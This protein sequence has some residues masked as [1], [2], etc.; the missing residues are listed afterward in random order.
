[1]LVCNNSNTR[2]DCWKYWVSEED[3]VR[4]NHCDTI[5]KLIEIKI[6]ALIVLLESK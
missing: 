5:D 3:T 4:Q 6:L 2:I 1:M